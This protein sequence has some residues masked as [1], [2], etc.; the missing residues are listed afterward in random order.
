MNQLSS[1]GLDGARPVARRRFGLLSY[2]GLYNLGDEIQSL[3]ARAFLPGVDRL[4]PRE[5]ID[6]DPGGEAPIG[7]ILNGWFMHAPG[8][9]PPH[10][11]LAVLPIS[12]HL[13]DIRPRRRDFWRRTP[14]TRI[15]SGEGLDYL[16]RNG[17]VGARDRATLALLERHGVEAYYSGCLTLTLTS[18]PG[19]VR[20]DEVLACDLPPPLLAALAGR[21]GR[22][23]RAISHYVDPATPAASRFAQAEALL[24]R[25]ARA[26]AVVT[27]PAPCRP[28]L[29]RARHAGP[30]RDRRAR[31]RRARRW[32]PSSPIIAKRGI[33]SPAAAPSTRAIR[34][35]TPTPICRSPPI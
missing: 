14:A 13:S 27:S 20:G 10:P 19:A 24:D 28:A 15:L 33:F 5:A 35:R 22:P 11:R 25:Y 23:P 9:W 30:V 32:A 34:R 16:R 3:A 18:P 4:V 8:H 1:S 17:P 26:K 31:P 2:P 6:R 12:F 21:L 29:S 7:L